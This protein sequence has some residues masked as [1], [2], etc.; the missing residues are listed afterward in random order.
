MKGWTKI[1]TGWYTHPSG[2]VVQ[3]W[4]SLGWFSWR[5]H[6]RDEDGR[7]HDTMREA[8]AWALDDPRQ[9]QARGETTGRYGGT[10]G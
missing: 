4:G 3:R 7:V 2:A 1:E 5:P 8:C 6:D 10:H 9:R